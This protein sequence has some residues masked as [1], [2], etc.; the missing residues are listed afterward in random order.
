MT[1][2]HTPSWQP[3]TEKISKREYQEQQAKSYQKTTPNPK[4]T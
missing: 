3:H 2:I 4:Q 1:V